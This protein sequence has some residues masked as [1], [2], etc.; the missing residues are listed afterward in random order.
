MTI[1]NFISIQ[2]KGNLEDIFQ[3]INRCIEIFMCQKENT[4]KK[5]WNDPLRAENSKVDADG[6][7]ICPNDKKSLFR[8]LFR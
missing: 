6:D 4:G 7:L 1:C 5:Y 8:V 2:L 3:E